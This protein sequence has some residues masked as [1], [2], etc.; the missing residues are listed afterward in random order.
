M[1]PVALGCPQQ[2]T[3]ARESETRIWAQSSWRRAQQRLSLAKIAHPG[4]GR[5]ALVGNFKV[6]GGTGQGHGHGA[7]SKS[8]HRVPAASTC[9][10]PAM[11]GPARPG[12]ERT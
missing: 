7:H 3:R 4:Q 11:P 9:C 8:R 2:G 5:P 12:R 10:G 1:G 6:P